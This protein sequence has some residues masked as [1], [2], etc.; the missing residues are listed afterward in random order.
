MKSIIATIIRTYEQ[1]VIDQ[2]FKGS[3]FEDKT[4]LL[5]TLLIAVSVVAYFIGSVNFAV[6]ISKKLG[7][8]VRDFGSGN[9][10]GTNMIRCFGKKIGIITILLDG[11]KSAVACII[12]LLIYGVTGALVAGFFCII[13]HA[14]PVYFK[15][16][17]GKGVACMAA[18][19]LITSPFV[20]LIMLAIYLVIL[21]GF[22]MVSLSSIM[23]ALMYPMIFSMVHGYGIQ[24][25]VA[26]LCSLFVVFFHRKN[27]ARI[28]YHEEP[29]INISKK[30]KSK[31]EPQEVNLTDE[32]SKE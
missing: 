24:I 2:N 18:M 32:N 22:K 3:F 30:K 10:G 12:G 29:K 14:Y 13:G 7:K 4:A 23:T 9:A 11:L 26:L 15:F 31:I 25:I 8:D 19:V 16:R 1:G 6:I 27:L 20:F 21:F 5:V 28:F 17:G